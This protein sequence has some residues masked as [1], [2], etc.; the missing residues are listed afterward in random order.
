MKKRPG[1]SKVEGEFVFFRF[2]DFR[3]VSEVDVSVM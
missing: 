2:Y 1:G 3:E